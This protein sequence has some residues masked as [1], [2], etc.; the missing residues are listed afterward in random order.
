MAKMRD[1]HNGG[2]QANE[3][4]HF[5]HERKRKLLKSSFTSDLVQM[6]FVENFMYKSMQVLSFTTSPTWEGPAGLWKSAKSCRQGCVRRETSH[7]PFYYSLSHKNEDS[8]AA[9]DQNSCVIQQQ[10]EALN[11]FKGVFSHARVNFG[12]FTSQMAGLILASRQKAGFCLKELSE[13]A[14]AGFE[15]LR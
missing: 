15:V 13:A 14:V 1:H 9:K 8:N 5:T 4:P 6:W 12:C 11:C 3:G 10:M 7:S 2:A